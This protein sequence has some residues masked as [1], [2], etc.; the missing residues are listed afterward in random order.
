MVTWLCGDIGLHG[1]VATWPRGC[2]VTGLR[3]Y[4]AIWFRGSIF[5]A[6]VAMQ[7]S[8]VFL[9]KISEDYPY[10]RML[11]LFLCFE[12]RDSPTLHYAPTLL[13]SLLPGPPKLRL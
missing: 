2:V 13:Q 9:A 6:N 10:P 8:I 4:L 5:E 7:V 1:F 3:S 11:H 12:E